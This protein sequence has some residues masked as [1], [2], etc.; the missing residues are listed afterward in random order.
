[1]ECVSENENFYAF[2]D[3]KKGTKFIEDNKDMYLLMK[4]YYTQL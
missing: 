4:I 3:S 1:M 2:V